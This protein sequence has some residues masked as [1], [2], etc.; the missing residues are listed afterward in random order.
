[1]TRPSPADVIAEWMH[2]DLSGGNT[3]PA[4]NDYV[5]ADSVIAALEAAGYRIVDAPSDWFPEAPHSRACGLI[6]HPHGPNCHTNC[7]T[8]HGLAWSRANATKE[9][10]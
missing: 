5:L 7:P 8:C 10:L 4:P 1:M 6:R 2:V 9:S 3:P